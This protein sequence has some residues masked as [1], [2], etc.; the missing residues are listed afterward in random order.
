MPRFLDTSTHAKI[1]LA[2]VPPGDHP[3]GNNVTG[4]VMS[5]MTANVL[6]F[7]VEADQRLPYDRHP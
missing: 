2:G 4:S 1:T 3:T 5:E 6:E 7:S